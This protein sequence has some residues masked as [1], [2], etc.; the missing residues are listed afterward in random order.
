MSV[1]INLVVQLHHNWLARDS[2]ASH[3]LPEQRANVLSNFEFLRVFERV[4]K[5]LKWDNDTKMDK[6]PNYLSGAGEEFHYIFYD[7]AD[8]SV[9]PV[10]WDDLKCLFLNHFMRGDYKSHFNK[11]L[12]R[13][14]KLESESMIVYITAIQ[15][16][17]HDL[18]DSKSR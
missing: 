3:Y 15:T 7:C 17:C 16:L 10:D 9:K 6:F 12:R 11:E 14:K 13:R 5:S 2:T 18:D 4:A 8:A 1:L